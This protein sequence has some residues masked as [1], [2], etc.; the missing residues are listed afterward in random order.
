MRTVL[1]PR[2]IHP[3]GAGRHYLLA[4]QNLCNYSIA[5][6]NYDKFASR[7]N[8]MMNSNKKTNK[9]V[10]VIICITF[11]L[12]MFYLSTKAVIYILNKRDVEG[13]AE[14]ILERSVLFMEQIEFV[15][16][17]SKSVNESAVCTKEHIKKLREILWPQR[18]IKDIAYANQGTLLC[19]ALWG[20]DLAPEKLNNNYNSVKYGKGFGCLM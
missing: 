1:L 16:S 11:T 12:S 6:L 9:Y 3:R 4:S 19:T 5:A 2:C 18:F 14:S 15:E 8:I 17:K 7:E 10:M 13:F 20:D